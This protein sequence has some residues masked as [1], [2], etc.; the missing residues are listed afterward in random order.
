MFVGA[1]YTH[2]IWLLLV[3]F[4]CSVVHVTVLESSVIVVFRIT[5]KFLGVIIEVT[6]GIR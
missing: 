5:D 2:L 1:V 6:F 3:L 4:D